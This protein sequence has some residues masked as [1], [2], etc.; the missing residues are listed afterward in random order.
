[1]TLLRVPAQLQPYIDVLG[2]DLGIRFLLAFGGSYIYLSER[3]QARSEVVYLVGLEN[4]V[5]LARRIGS[6]SMRVHSGKPFIARYFKDKGR[7]VNS[8]ARE[9]HTT[10]VTVR[11][12]LKPPDDRQMKLL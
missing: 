3:P 10:D 7:T 1:M 6:G 8:I 2:E 11:G 9:L 5:A 4:A 12:W